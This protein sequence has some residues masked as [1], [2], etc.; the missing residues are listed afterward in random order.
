VLTRNPHFQEWS[1]EAQPAG[2]PDRIEWQ[3]D[4][5][6][7]T[8]PDDVPKRT[9][10]AVE[11]G[12]SD[13]A[14]A[15]EAGPQGA[16]E[17]RFGARLH[18]TPTETLHGLTLNTR[19]PPFNDMRVRQALAL[20]I[21]R[22][23]IKAHWSIP[24]EITCQFLPPNFAGHRPY[25][26]YTRNPDSTGTWHG[27]D[28]ARAQA[29]VKASHTTGMPV[30]VYASTASAAGMRDVVKALK[31]LGYRADTFVDK[32]ELHHFYFAADTRN[33]VQAASFGWVASD[34]SPA[35]FLTPWACVAITPASRHNLNTAQF[36]DPAIDH[37]AELA[38]RA[39][40]TSLAEANELWA[41][42]DKRLVD[43]EPWIP[44][45]TPT[46]VDAVST[47]VHNYKRNLVIG[48]L[49][50]QMWLR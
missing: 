34:P 12:H 39:Q 15:R 38:D 21:D 50:D 49:F 40:T 6:A 2:F 26:P 20:A 11:A 8:S 3:V 45:V 1:A 36:C 37:V 9:V 46:W 35:N 31:D 42:E 16:L 44:L 25:C 4:A 22:D 5:Q 14:D 13:W 17:A 33:N 24:A 32:D 43:A 28:I 27:A 19:I 23:A 48:P 30:T 7:E 29:L 10:D 41:Q 47:R 18:S